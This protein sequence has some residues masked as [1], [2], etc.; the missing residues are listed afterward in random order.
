MAEQAFAASFEAVLAKEGTESSELET[1]QAATAECALRSQQALDA[2]VAH[3]AQTNAAE[4][5]LDKAFAEHIRLKMQCD[6]L[7]AFAASVEGRA[8]D[9]SFGANWQAAQNRFAVWGLQLAGCPS[10]SDTSASENW[11]QMDAEEAEQLLSCIRNELEVQ[12][13]TWRTTE[14]SKSAT[15]A[16]KARSET[17]L[18]ENYWQ[19]VWA[20]KELAALEAQLA[21]ASDEGPAAVQLKADVEK[22]RTHAAKRSRMT[23]RALASFRAGQRNLPENV[24][25]AAGR[26][27]PGPVT[28]DSSAASKAAAPTTAPI[29]LQQLATISPAHTAETPQPEEVSAEDA[30]KI[31]EAGV[32]T[33]DE[34]IRGHQSNA[35][36]LLNFKHVPFQVDARPSWYTPGGTIKKWRALA[37]CDGVIVPVTAKGD[38][39]DD[40]FEFINPLI[41][42]GLTVIARNLC[43][44]VNHEQDEV[45]LESN[46]SM[47]VLQSNANGLVQLRLPQI[48]CRS[49]ICQPQYSQVHCTLC[50]W[51]SGKLNSGVVKVKKARNQLELVDQKGGAVKAV[52]FGAISEHSCWQQVVVVKITAATVKPLESRLVIDEHSNVAEVGLAGSPG[53]FPKPVAVT[54]LEWPA[55]GGEVAPADGC[56]FS[57]KSPGGR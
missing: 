21:E 41:A 22:A 50:V 12:C 39:A 42:E 36:L 17:F 35:A 46:F 44:N 37:A 31:Q 18:A 19:G 51:R 4:E 20:T 49:I 8:E 45:E 43:H 56:S 40:A 9:S 23:S 28:F 6:T 15:F 34:F 7:L 48:D 33:L 26:H 5:F 2:F 32:S 3:I 1:A 55:Q 53:A 14:K 10:F 16:H 11:E 47:A 52:A 25:P 30:R 27:E 29:A 24:V 13:T 38:V 54:M 57:P